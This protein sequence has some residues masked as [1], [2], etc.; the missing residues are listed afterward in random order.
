M[1]AAVARDAWGCMRVEAKRGHRASQPAQDL[2]TH[3]PN[4]VEPGAG[5]ARLLSA[6]DWLGQVGSGVEAGEVQ[7]QAHLQAAL[8]EDKGDEIGGACSCGAAGQRDSC[9]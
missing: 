2:F 4:A 8:I 9:G 6:Q 5:K 1:G 7:V 3:S